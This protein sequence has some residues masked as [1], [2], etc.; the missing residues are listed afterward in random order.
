MATVVEAMRAE[1]AMV[2]GIGRYDLALAETAGDRLVCKAGGEAIECVALTDRG[3]GVTV[4]VADGGTRAL[5]VATTEILR[6]LDV[7]TA[8]EVDKLQPFATPLLKNHRQIIT[9]RIRPAVDL[10]PR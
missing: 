10:K 1:P 5:G 3:W 2:S 9:G 7:L 8:A 4:K 6:Q